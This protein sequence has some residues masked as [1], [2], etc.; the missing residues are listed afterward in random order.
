MGAPVGAQVDEEG[1]EQP[2]MT[3][4]VSIQ[5]DADAEWTV[6]L[7]YSLGENDADAFDEFGRDYEDG[8]TGVLPITVFEAA[9]RQAENATGRSM[10]IENMERD[11][12]RENQT[13]YLLL[14]FVWTNFSRIDGDQL[15]LG[16]V[17]Q[18]ED[19]TW[20]PELGENQRLIIE[21]P[22][23]YSVRSSS[24]PLQADAFYVEGPV[25][26]EPGEPSADLEQI[27]TGSPPDTETPAEESIV[28]PIAGVGFFVV[29]TVAVSYLYVR[30]N[31][32]VGGSSDGESSVS[33]GSGMAVD[34]ASAEETPERLLSDEERVLRL[35]QENDGRMKQVDIVN[36]TNWSN[37]KVSQLLS[38]MDS[39][40]KIDKLRI[41]RENLIS[42]PDDSSE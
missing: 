26:F 16:D 10:Q 17:F 15:F 25:S 8:R 23:D 42:L 5:S 28:P 36:E 22:D 39:E 37:A 3:M 4:R 2:T 14:E 11:S 12:F 13:G 7:G 18:S 41:G 30:R 31:Q 34:E 33:E 21:F 29:L 19:G 38:E 9:A 20:L 6:R 24:R 35:L 1:S 40:E 27:E 32:T